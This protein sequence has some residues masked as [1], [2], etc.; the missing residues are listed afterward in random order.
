M[1]L[2]QSRIAGRSCN[3]Q[4][5]IPWALCSGAR[6]SELHLH[7]S[8]VTRWCRECRDNGRDISGWGKMMEKWWLKLNDDFG[9]MIGILGYWVI[10][11]H[12]LPINMMNNMKIWLIGKTTILKNSH[13][14]W[15]RYELSLSIIKI[16]YSKRCWSYGGMKIWINY[17]LVKLTSLYEKSSCFIGN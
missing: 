17:P 10:P 12:K 1:A 16:P 7:G 6:S 3:D 9:N 2:H 4:R 5:L 8:G 15:G 11:I 13:V 14:L